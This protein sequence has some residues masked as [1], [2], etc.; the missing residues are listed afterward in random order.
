MRSLRNIQVI[1][2][3]SI[4]FRKLIHNDIG[5]EWMRQINTHI[6]VDLNDTVM[7]GWHIQKMH[8]IKFVKL[9][10]SYYYYHESFSRI[11]P[12]Q[13]F[14]I[15]KDFPF[16]QLVFLLHLWTSR[17]TTFSCT[18]LW[19]VQHAHKF[20]PFF[21]SPDL[22]EAMKQILN[23][24]AYKSIDK[25]SFS[26]RLDLCNRGDFGRTWRPIMGDDDYR[27]LSKKLGVAVKIATYLACLAGLVTNS[28]LIAALMSTRNTDL[29]KDYKHYTYLRLLAFLSGITLTIQMTGWLTECAYPY[30]L[31]CPR[32]RKFVAAQLYKLVFNECLGNTLKFMCNFVYVAFAFNRIALI[33]KDHCKLTKFMCDVSVRGFVSTCAALSLVLSVIKCFK[34]RVNFGHP[35]SEYPTSNELDANSHSGKDHGLFAL[36]YI[37]NTVSDLLN[38]FGF[39][40]VNFGIDVYMAVRM[41]NTLD[42]KCKRLAQVIHMVNQMLLV[43][44]NN[45]TAA[46]TAVNKKKETNNE[47]A[48]NN[49]IKFVVLNTLIGVLFKLPMSF[50]SL[51]NLCAEF[52][53]HYGSYASVHPRFGEFYSFLKMSGFYFLLADWANFLYVFSLAIQLFVYASFD[54][55]VKVSIERLRNN[56]IKQQTVVI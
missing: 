26:S 27:G 24:S 48:L 10:S 28:I 20:A 5:I 36:F 38:F 3:D 18:Y 32:A 50:L 8:D 29:F 54:K 46:A 23:S 42:D 47:E 25:C 34:Y 4:H 56:N 19:L 30:E 17:P 13:D 55:K 14:C 51:V 22:V 45:V 33:G 21:K 7:I 40:C 16:E 53:Y 39:V 15:Y 52:Y 9:F 2:L 44:S 1:T 11:F 41:R 31:L 43:E 35:E 12:D 49:A 37:L 6:R